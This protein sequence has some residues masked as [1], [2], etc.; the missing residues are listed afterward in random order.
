[1]KLKTALSLFLVSVA[2]IV[3][4]LTLALEYMANQLDEGAKEITQT[5]ESIRV[6]EEMES[7]ILIHNRDMFLNSL[8]Q[9]RVPRKALED[10]EVE[11]RKLLNE[12]ERY[13]SSAEEGA[14][15]PMIR[16]AV[17][18]YFEV[19]H[20]D[21]DPGPL[22]SER[23]KALNAVVEN[24][25]ATMDRFIDIN[26]EQARQTQVRIDQQNRLATRLGA[27]LISVAIIL[28][29]C[30]FGLSLS[31]VY[32]PLMKL[33]KAISQYGHGKTDAR[34][35]ITGLKETREIAATFNAMADRLEQRRQDQLNF[36]ASIAHD[37]RNPLNSISMASELLLEKE[38]SADRHLIEIVHRQVHGL[39]R[40]VS[41]LM[42]TTR[43]ESGHLELKTARIEIVSLVRQAVELYKASSP[44][45]RFD[46]EAPSTPIY[47]RIDPDRISQVF[48]NL[49][50]NAIKY[51]PNGG[52]I[53][54]RCQVQDGW[55]AFDITDSGI[56]IGKEDIDSIFKPFNRSKATRDMIPGIGLGLSA[57]RKIIDAH[58]GKLSV[59]SELRKGSCFRIALPLDS[60]PH[61][62]TADS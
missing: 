26:I 34:A 9:G 16:K 31:T 59:Q 10:I 47:C 60:Y 27:S 61:L 51:S 57:S 15:L 37:L 33:K 62:L 32:R 58:G 4:A 25:I 56:G 52:P 18:E 48:N 55:F 39:D 13:I 23:H 20:Q 36:I 40:L 49:I 50:S 19:S 45:H 5:A 21:E 41:D 11:T 44:L 38:V 14:L 6:G 8:Q 24:L 3:L 1:M 30:M 35:E 12:A 53:G 42:D 22:G 29:L 2:A 17:E 46:L 43:I 7:N 54:I 28:I